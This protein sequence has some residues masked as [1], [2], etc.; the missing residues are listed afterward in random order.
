MSVDVSKVRFSSTA[1]PTAEDLKLWHSLS[2]EE[3]RAVI[4]RDVREGL[5]GAVARKF[6]K[7]EL[8]AQVLAE[9]ADAL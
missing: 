8:V 2:D 1:F 4:L 6:G 9:Y 5:D 3:K 7:D